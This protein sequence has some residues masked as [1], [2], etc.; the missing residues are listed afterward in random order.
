[1][2]QIRFRP[3]L[4]PGPRSG[5]LQHL[6]DLLALVGLRGILLL[7]GGEGKGRKRIGRGGKERVRGGEGEGRGGG[8][9]SR[10]IPSINSLLLVT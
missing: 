10:N 8:K 5:R 7:R 2:H 6:P 1:M 3:G 9:E 4:R